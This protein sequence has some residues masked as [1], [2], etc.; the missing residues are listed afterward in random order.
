MD[1]K[2]RCP[3]SPDEKHDDVHVGY[4][5]LAGSNFYECRYC[6]EMKSEDR[7]ANRRGSNG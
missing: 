2:E 4:G 6:H 7:D 5:S 1:E 3:D